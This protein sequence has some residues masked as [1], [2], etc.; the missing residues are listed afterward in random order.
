MTS[1]CKLLLQFKASVIPKLPHDYMKSDVYL[2]R[3]LRARNFNAKK[4][5]ELIL[6]NIK[7]RT[8]NSMDTILE[9]DWADMEEEY[10]FKLNSHDK[11]GKP[12]FLGA[13]GH[14]DLRKA[15]VTGRFPRLMRYGE[16][17][18][19]EEEVLIRKLQAEGKMVTR[20]VIIFDM[21]GFNI[22]QHGCARCINFLLQFYSSYEDHHPGL[23]S[24]MFVVNNH[25]LVNTLLQPFLVSLAPGTR[26]TVVLFNRNRAEYSKA[27]LK[28][29]DYD[30]LPEKYGGS[31]EEE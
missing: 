30:Q 13:F 7:W 14:W 16:R 18:L 31:K 26:D 25:P 15:E 22:F 9:E 11:E 24:K 28:Y 12:V 10:P 8:D 20:T 27:L 21:D 3:W 5:E 29:I 6:E 17:I 19:E 4:A 1:K 23:M 2:I